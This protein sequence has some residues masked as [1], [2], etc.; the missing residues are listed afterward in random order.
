[1][2]DHAAIYKTADGKAKLTDDEISDIAKYLLSLKPGSGA[3]DQTMGASTGGDVDAVELFN[4]NCSACHS[5][6]DDKIVGPGLAGIGD[7]AGN[8]VDGLSADEYLEQSLREPDAYI[9]DGFTPGLMPNWEKLG[10]DS[11][12]ALVTY[13]KTMK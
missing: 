7:R 2:Q 8:R 10:D 4:A 1:M 12:D 6:G 5:T 11:I 3:T 9:V 13:L